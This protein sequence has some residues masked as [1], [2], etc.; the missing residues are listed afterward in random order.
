[1]S[2]IE[3]RNGQ[4]STLSRRRKDLDELLG[5][6]NSCHIYEIRRHYSYM[7]HGKDILGKRIV[8]RLYKDEELQRL[9][10][11]QYI[12]NTVRAKPHGN[13]SKNEQNQVFWKI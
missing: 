12:G 7:K 1:M 4:I 13:S 3:V 9:A 5:K 8:S 11:I 10:V 2:L 6:E